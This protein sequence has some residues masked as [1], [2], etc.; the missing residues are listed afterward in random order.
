MI[1]DRKIIR[2]VSKIKL[3]SEQMESESDFAS[4]F[5]DVGIVDQIDNANNQVLFGRRGTGKTHTINVLCSRLRRSEKAPVLFVDLRNVGSSKDMLPKTDITSV[6]LGVF[7]DLM[8]R[9]H[10]LL[11]DEIVEREPN[12]ADHLLNLADDLIT[13]IM[14]P[15]EQVMAREMQSETTM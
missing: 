8:S 13:A 5:V 14:D 12:D 15:V 3:R 10:W 6:G 4:A 7:R 11:V 1:D 9:V 2:A